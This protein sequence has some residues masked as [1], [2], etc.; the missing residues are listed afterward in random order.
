MLATDAPVVLREQRIEA[1]IPDAAALIRRLR[2]G[3]GGNEAQTLAKPAGRFDR[4]RVVRSI[5]SITHVLNHAVVL[6]GRAG[7]DVA[8]RARS[9]LV[10]VLEAV[11]VMAFRSQVAQLDHPIL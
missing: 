4:P 10:E 1:L 6:E 7:G 5:Q 2:E 8:H 3:V 11:E 9:C